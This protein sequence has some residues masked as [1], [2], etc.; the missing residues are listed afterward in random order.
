MA[1][2]DVDDLATTSEIEVPATPFTAIS[3]AAAAMI[4]E[5]EAAKKDGDT[6]GGI[7][8]VLAYGTAV[9]FASSRH[10]V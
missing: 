9:Y 7:V 10:G 1:P 2:A 5:V 4:A 8:E 6:L 3:S